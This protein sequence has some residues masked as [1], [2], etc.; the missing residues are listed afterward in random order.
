MIVIM[1]I[2]IIQ[3]QKETV[4]SIKM[5]IKK[6]KPKVTKIKKTKEEIMKKIM[7]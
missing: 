3:Y 5:K 6:G 7:H 4:I 2:Q 1:I